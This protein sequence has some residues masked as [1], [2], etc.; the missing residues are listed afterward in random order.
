MKVCDI[1]KPVYFQWAAGIPNLVIHSS[2]SIASSVSPESLVGCVL[3]RFLTK[4]RKHGNN[5]LCTDN[6]LV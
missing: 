4:L 2:I 5:A 3:E 1:T 6:S